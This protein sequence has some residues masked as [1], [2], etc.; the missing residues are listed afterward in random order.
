[1]KRTL[2][3]SKDGREGFSHRIVQ[4]SPGGSFW[5]SLFFLLRLFRRVRAADAQST[6]QI[7]QILF[8][9]CRSDRAIRNS[10]HDLTERLH[11]DIPR[12]VYA[13]YIRLL[14]AIRHDI[15]RRIQLDLPFQKA[16][17][18]RI[19]DEDE[20]PE[21]I[22]RSGF[23]GSLFPAIPI[24]QDDATN[25]AVSFYPC[26]FRAIGNRHIRVFFQLF[27]RSRG[28][29]KIRAAHDDMDFP[30]VLR[31]KKCFL[32]RRI[33]AADDEDVLSGEELAI[34][35]RAVGD[36]VSAK[37]HFPGKARKPWMCAGCIDETHRLEVSAVG[38]YHF[39]ITGE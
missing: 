37:F 32:D 12:C 1:M 8:H 10:R 5:L 13:G 24:S 34:T 11:A 31:E 14:F 19:A 29:R 18:R 7:S 28:N 38:V 15:A 6:V 35:G 30:C 3:P 20:D 23:A 27:N 21:E 9:G 22:I 36:T 2:K 39:R 4:E 16:A 26:D 33:P 17:F 25:R